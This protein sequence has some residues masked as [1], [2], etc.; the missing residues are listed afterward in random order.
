MRMSMSGRALAAWCAAGLLLSAPA[1]GEDDA[2][3][4]QATAPVAAAPGTTCA[5]TEGLPVPE[6]FAPLVAERKARCGRLEPYRQ[7]WFEKQLLLVEK[8]ERPPIGEWNV[9]G[10][11][12]RLQA[13]DHR[14]QLA[15]GA[16]FWQPN[17]LHS[18]FDV[19]GAFFYSKA[20]FEYGEGQA[21]VLPQRGD[22]LPPFAF[23]GDDVFELVNVREDDNHRY[24][25]YGQ[26]YYRWSPRYDFYGTG[27]DSSKEDRSDFRQKDNM[28][29][30][31][32]GLRLLGKLS[33]MARAGRWVV[34]TGE[35]T[36]DALPNVDEV[37]P[38]SEIP[39][40]GERLEY[41]R[42][43]ASL[44]FDGRDVRGNPHRGGVVAVQALQF[45]RRAG[46][47]PSFNRVSADA[48]LYLPL[49][50]RQRVLALRTYFT[51][52]DAEGDARVPFFALPAVGSGSTLRGYQ[53]QRLRG[54]RI[55]LLQAEYRVELA[56]ALEL[57]LFY[58]TAAVAASVDDK[59]G[60]WR[61]NG[62]FGLRFKTHEDVLARADFAWGREGFRALFRFGPS[63]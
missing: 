53:S 9:L 38:P 50:H 36:D 17:L 33:L 15:I 14:S 39:F 24:A 16:R 35:G 22:A 48:R 10:L 60:N 23:K 44:V 28:L 32:G 41:D 12:P 27:P 51:R 37:F 49:G 43:G 5:S 31:V 34:S 25:L 40:Y 42:W 7:G 55:W 45:D 59:V 46:A 54:E 2:V 58:D 30:A 3:G 26:W 57:A 21:G 18:A 6:S 56:P 63:F 61:G 20:G 13:I 52:D 8:A 1:R 4:G 29:E 19:H 11:Y 62:G 47:A